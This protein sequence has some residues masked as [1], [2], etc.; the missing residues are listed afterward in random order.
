[1]IHLVPD[2]P[3]GV[4]NFCIIPI[5]MKGLKNLVK[6]SYKKATGSTQCVSVPVAII[7][8][9]RDWNNP[10][11]AGFVRPYVKDNFALLDAFLAF[12]IFIQKLYG[13][14]HHSGTGSLG[15]IF[16]RTRGRTGVRRG[17]FQ[18]FPADNAAD[19]LPE[20]FS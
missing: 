1:M 8:E 3:L 13:K 9:D 19:F 10:N 14:T 4:W 6:E 2:T 15:V 16:C 20:L 12:Y 7:I 18:N 17:I 5:F 11:T